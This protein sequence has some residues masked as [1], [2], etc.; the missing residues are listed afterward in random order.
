MKARKFILFLSVGLP[1]FVL[2]LSMTPLA[3]SHSHGKLVAHDSD[4]PGHNGS[5]GN[6]HDPCI[7]APSGQWQG[8]G[9]LHFFDLNGNGEHDHES[10]GSET[11]R[12]VC[13]EGKAP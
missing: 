5:S 9:E 4:Q 1:I 6:T 11:E 3:E 8:T 13:A 2:A 12:T 10:T 7:A